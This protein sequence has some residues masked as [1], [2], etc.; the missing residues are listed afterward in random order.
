MKTSAVQI[1]LFNRLMRMLYSFTLVIL[2]II[3]CS[4]SSDIESSPIAIKGVL[5]LRNWDFEKD[6]IIDLNWEWDYS[7]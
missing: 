2:L 6:G 4:S 7:L 5:D 1:E 3:S